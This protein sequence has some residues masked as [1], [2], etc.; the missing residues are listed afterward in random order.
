MKGSAGDWWWHA[1]IKAA[2]HTPWCPGPR[3]THKGLHGA[4]CHALG[5]SAGTLGSA[6]L[7]PA[8]MNAN[9]KL[10]EYQ[11]YHIISHVCS[12]SPQPLCTH[13]CVSLFLPLTL[14]R[15]IGNAFSPSTGA[16]RVCRLCTGFFSGW[17][18]I[19]SGILPS[20]Q[21]CAYVCI[22]AL[23]SAQARVLCSLS[24]LERLNEQERASTHRE[25]NALK[26][27]LQWEWIIHTVS[28]SFQGFP[29]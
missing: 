26:S 4:I 15:P 20:L 25:D 1:C 5:I 7:C 19:W 17:L 27:S 12:R 6:G 2:R 8:Q 11:E 18:V 10:M 29:K 16:E 13:T 21:W 22:R 23:M 28:A 14:P 24:V 9:W 3:W